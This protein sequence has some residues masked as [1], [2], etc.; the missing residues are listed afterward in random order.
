MLRGN[1][2]EGSTCIDLHYYGSKT[3]K[4]IS[5]AQSA[6]TGGMLMPATAL[7]DSYAL[8]R[9]AAETQRLIRQAQIYAPL[10]RQFFAAA[11]I[12]AGMK[13]LDIGSGAGDVALLLADMVG[14]QGS[15]IGVEMNPVILDTARERVA[16][17]GW[18][19]VTFL[20]G[21]VRDIHLDN[22]FDAVVGRWVLMYLP[23]PVAV[24]QL[25]LRHMNPGGIVA[26]Q[27]SDFTY[28]PMALPPARVHQQVQQWTTP[29]PGS[30]GP[31]QQTGSKLHQIYQ[32]AGL[33]APQ[34]RLTAP[35]GGGPEWPGY[36]YVADTVR[37]LLPMLQQMGLVTAEDVD[38]DTLADRLRA[39]VVSQGGVQ[40]LPMVIG[41]WARHVAL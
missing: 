34:L 33:P 8:G 4:P 36:A 9:S 21:D 18:T 19:N 39:E 30:R 3:S 23:D 27:E 6:P 32:D 41:A 14:P 13:V 5:N 1:A 26:F 17:A 35:I 40:M 24:L 28:P 7:S 29:P 22:D 20:A 16:A 11:G 2:V 15:V 38:I 25:L 12:T 10:T 31:D 37:S